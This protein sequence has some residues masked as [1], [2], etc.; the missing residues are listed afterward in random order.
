MRRLVLVAVLVAAL[1]VARHVLQRPDRPLM[2]GL[3]KQQMAREASAR[4]P[5]PSET[6]SLLI[7]TV[8]ARKPARQDSNLRA[9]A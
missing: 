3:R 6:R 2:T 1:I 4:P 7:T 8:D 5:G 9:P